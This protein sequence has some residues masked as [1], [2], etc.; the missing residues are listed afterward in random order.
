MATIVVTGRDDQ[1]TSRSKQHTQEKLAKLERYFDGIGRIEAVLG[2]SGADAAVELV[3]SV[4]NGKTV[5]CSSQARELYTAL[6]LVLDK[7]EKQLTRHKERLKSH[8]DQRASKTQD[9][10]VPAPDPD[11]E[12]EYGD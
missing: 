11:A 9:L 10:N 1:I 3:I 2:H 12:G 7:A 8:R 6:D 5:V 4:G